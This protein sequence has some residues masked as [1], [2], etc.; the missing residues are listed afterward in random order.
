MVRNISA[1]IIYITYLRSSLTD[2]LTASVPLPDLGKFPWT[3]FTPW[4]R[5]AR[6]CTQKLIENQWIFPIWFYKHQNWTPKILIKSQE[7]YLL[8][9]HILWWSLFIKNAQTLEMNRKIIDM[10][11]GDPYKNSRNIFHLQSIK[12]NWI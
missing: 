4:C 3:F 2:W 1:C 7:N 5:D 6:L 11:E 12:R 9:R 8:W 10:I